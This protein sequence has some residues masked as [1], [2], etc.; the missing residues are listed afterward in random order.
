MSV[1]DSVFN[2]VLKAKNLISGETE[3][4]AEGL[5]QLSD[6]VKQYGDN[7]S[8]LKQAIKLEQQLARLEAQ[9]QSAANSVEK[10][11]ASYEQSA[12]ELAI[13]DEAVERLNGR[14]ADAQ[15]EQARLQKE[16]GRTGPTEKLLAAYRQATNQVDL[17]EETLSRA[18][19]EQGQWARAVQQAGTRLDRAKLAQEKYANQ[20]A[21]TSKKLTEFKQA[22]GL[23][24]QGVEQLEQ[25]LASANT[26]LQRAKN[27]LKAAQAEAR[28]TAQAMQQAGAQAEGAGGKFARFGA[29]LVGSLTKGVALVGSIG[30]GIAGWKVT[31]QFKA[32]VQSGVSF[33]QQMLNVAA[34][35]NATESELALLTATAEEMGASTKYTATQAGEAL[36]TLVRAGYSA[37]DSIKLLP[38][39]LQTATAAK[40]DLAAAAG[41]VSDQL[42]IFERD[43]SQATATTDVLSKGAAL[44][45]TSISDIAEAM[46]T[47]G[48]QAVA[49]GYSLE[50]MTAYIDVLAK[51][52][53]RGG[54]AGTAL[55][56]ILA[57]LGDPS[58]KSRKELE[59][60]GITSNNLTDVIAGLEQAGKN[61]EAAILAFGLEAGPALR[62]LISGGAEEVERLTRALEDSA[63]STE[64][65]AARMGESTEEALQG[66]TSAY[67]AAGRKLA[68]PMLAVISSEAKLLAQDLRDLAAG[69][70]LDQMGSKIAEITQKITSSFRSWFN[71]IDYSTVTAAL[72]SVSS[73]VDR[74]I[75]GIKDGATFVKEWS[76]ELL[77]LGQVLIGLRLAQMAAS[78]TGLLGGFIGLGRAT[79][80]AGAG[81]ASAGGAF[82]GLLSILRLIPLSLPIAI[83]VAGGEALA[84]AVAKVKELITYGES[85]DTFTE[86]AKARMQATAMAYVKTAQQ[87]I[88]ANSQFADF[89]RLSSERLSEMT[90]QELASYKERLA[91]AERYYRAK[92]L[93]NK[94]LEQLGIQ[95]QFDTD[96]SGVTKA[97]SEIDKANKALAQTQQQASGGIQGLGYVAESATGKI[98][99]AA[100]SMDELKRRFPDAKVKAIQVGQG[101]GAAATAA[102]KT[103][104]ALKQQAEAAKDATEANAALVKS[105]NT[106]RTSRQS[107][108][109]TKIAF[110]AQI[111]KAKTLD[112][113]RLL[114]QQLAD[115]MRDKTISIDAFQELNPKIQQQLAAL[116]QEA[117]G[118]AQATKAEIESALSDVKAK[119]D[120]ETPQVEPVQVPVT[121]DTAAVSSQLQAMA[122]D[123]S[124]Y[125]TAADNTVHQN[126]MAK[127][128]EYQAAL[129]RL[130][131]AGGDELANE[132]L[133]K[134]RRL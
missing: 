100:N 85:S 21:E 113:F 3:K 37:S 39:V 93:Q 110:K 26:D 75:S 78:V 124:A 2:L 32:A 69:N 104:G 28:Q 95:D 60:L 117:S 33:E 42:S 64:K 56:N 99:G 83:A 130:S 134:G 41:L 108:I 114:E 122:T 97:L 22:A 48:G 129:Q 84:W 17:Y 44:A 12:K 89:E 126:R 10:L 80:Q 121:A 15:K 65:T 63:G 127:L 24:D 79:A 123:Y 86:R 4:A 1:K 7:V 50:T 68:Q 105:L 11:S 47:A 102:D 51:R 49:Y 35:S 71:D 109:E 96:V 54:E 40:I 128:S 91:G 34:A 73:S 76:S 9:S 36:E 55:R 111:D 72:D 87:M 67:D 118:L 53:I 98:L 29:G 6:S 81:A 61:G 45:N 115:A 70:E 74:V 88:D 31:Q 131:A 27:N 57:Q 132:A 116:R 103:T 125:M 101:F 19:T 58:S 133:K 5:D 46:K 92:A 119:V 107:Q 52:A 23:A 90:A 13:A 20:L 106:D 16:M 94:A 112:D 59:A 30:A 43:A 8:N 62:A 77:V 18:K 66:L 82:R 38:A 14:L 120:I 25:G